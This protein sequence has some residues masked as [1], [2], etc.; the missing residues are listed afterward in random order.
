M[1]KEINNFSIVLNTL[2]LVS[3]THWLVNQIVTKN[4][5]F[6]KSFK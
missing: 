5:S 2:M 6:K 4:N 3:D 1:H